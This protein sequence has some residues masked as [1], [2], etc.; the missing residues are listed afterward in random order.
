MPLRFFVIPIRDDGAAADA[1]NA[2][3][4]GCRVLAVDRRWVDQGADSFWSICVDYV[5]T[6]AAPATVNNDEVSPAPSAR[7]PGFQVNV[8]SLSISIAIPFI[9]AASAA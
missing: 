2:F 1:L 7:S 9:R 4:R 5:E 3:L 8:K 6:N